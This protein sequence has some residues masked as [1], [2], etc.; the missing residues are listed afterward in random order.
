MTRKRENGAIHQPIKKV[1]RQSKS[2]R[3]YNPLA[4]PRRLVSKDLTDPRPNGLASADVK[5]SNPRTVKLGR[6][7]PR[8]EKFPLNF[9]AG[10]EESKWS[11]SMPIRGASGRKRVAETGAKR[12]QSP[13]FR[14][15]RCV[16]AA[17]SSAGSR[18]SWLIGAVRARG[19][20]S[21]VGV[22][23]ISSARLR[24]S[25]GDGHLRQRP[26]I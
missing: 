21:F 16:C 12:L 24:V 15:A 20:H 3:N 7:S 22:P 14:S 9:L 8:S 25:E 5:Q 26:R 13:L 2:W 1:I 6:F 4:F 10:R 23:L 18:L 11:R 19:V 17:R